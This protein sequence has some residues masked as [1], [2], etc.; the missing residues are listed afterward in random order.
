M[1]IEHILIICFFLVIDSTSSSDSRYV[2]N[3]SNHV[4]TK[5]KNMFGCSSFDE[6][7]ESNLCSLHDAF[8]GDILNEIAHM[9]LLDGTNLLHA[10]YGT[11]PWWSSSLKRAPDRKEHQ[12]FLLLVSSP[13]F[14]F[15]F[16]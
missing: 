3:T 8:D 11:C 9:Q 10:S 14:G 1:V 16:V 2:Q 4:K 7:D 12:K 13:P 5:V 6:I 15:Y